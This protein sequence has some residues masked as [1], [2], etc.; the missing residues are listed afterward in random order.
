[1]GTYKRLAISRL[2]MTLVE[3]R[4]ACAASLRAMLELPVKLLTMSHGRPLVADAAAQL[5][6]AVQA[7]FPE[8][9]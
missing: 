1:M 5:A 9:R 6:Q 8:L 2:V 7:R 4:E 3:D